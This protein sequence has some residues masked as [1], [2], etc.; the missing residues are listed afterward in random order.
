MAVGV[1]DQCSVGLLK[2]FLVRDD[3]AYRGRLVSQNDQSVSPGQPRAVAEP[4]ALH[5]VVLSTVGELQNNAERVE[6]FQFRSRCSR[7]TNVATDNGSCS[8]FVDTPTQ[9][10]RVV[11]RAGDSKLARYSDEFAFTAVVAVLRHDSGS[12]AASSTLA[13]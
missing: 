1:P 2:E 6:S 10:R 9:R 13:S 4:L 11:P 8:S 7:M 3:V 5:S 12:R